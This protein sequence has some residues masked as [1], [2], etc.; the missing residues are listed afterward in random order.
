MTKV[1]LGAGI[2]LEKSMVLL[3]C[4]VWRVA[5][6]RACGAGA[7]ITKKSQVLSGW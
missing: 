3:G 7:E 2:F 4:L 5:G 1:L 6:K